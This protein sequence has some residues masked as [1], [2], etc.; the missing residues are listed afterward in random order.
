MADAESDRCAAWPRTYS[1]RE[2]RPSSTFESAPPRSRDAERGSDWRPRGAIA[3]GNRSDATSTISE[4]FVRTRSGHAK[5]LLAHYY[6]TEIII[7]I[8]SG[9]PPHGPSRRSAHSLDAR[10]AHKVPANAA[11]TENEHTSG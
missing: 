10:L 9:R 5:S 6:G 8:Q 2:Y 3:R 1:W 7:N 4:V 11:Q